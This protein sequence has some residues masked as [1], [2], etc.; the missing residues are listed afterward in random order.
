MPG[1]EFTPTHLVPAAGLPYWDDPDAERAPDGRADPGLE[2]MVLEEELGWARV[3]FSNGWETWVD[4][5]RLD[6]R[7]Q[8]EPEPALEAPPTPAAAFV[9]T[10]AVPAGGLDARAAPDAGT[11]VEHRLDAGLD[12]MVLEEVSG[13]A[14]VRCSNGWEAWVDGR[15]L[16]PLAAPGA[17]RTAPIAAG[18]PV[19]APTGRAP[20]A[21]LSPRVLVPAVGA[22]LVIIGSFLPWYSFD[23]ETLSA[24]DVPLGALAS[25]SSDSGID[26]GPVLLLV[27]LALVPLLTRRPFPWGVGIVIAGVA[28]N[29]GIL[30]V[31]RLL[32]FPIASPSMGIGLVL[33][34]VG[35]ALMVLG[36]LAGRRVRDAAP[37]PAIAG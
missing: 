8:P 19:A 14:R 27:A 25:N 37:T 23:G 20:A 22:A 36:T 29:I 16:R 17:E 3:R 32:D 18:P 34:L 13:W 5:R 35:G 15:Q 1:V 11:L 6:V 4:G 9:A 24:W 28:T 10:H 31:R 7:P 26:T 12:V 2:V 21:G 30:G 33:V